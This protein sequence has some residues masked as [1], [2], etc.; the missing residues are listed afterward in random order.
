M[1]TDKDW[2][3]GWVCY[4]CLGLLANGETPEN[5]DEEQTAAWLKEIERRED[6]A[7]VTLGLMAS[8][9]ESSCPNID[10]DGD[11]I[12]GSECQCERQEFS[13]SQCNLCG[14][15]LGGS[16]DAVTFWFDKQ[17]TEVGQ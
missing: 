2:A 10:E 16:R 15:R 11:W 17:A 1:S 3:T 7:D 12:G 14:S 13:W 4:D 6:G 5:M 9:H 8:E